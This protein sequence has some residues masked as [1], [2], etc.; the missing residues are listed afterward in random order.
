MAE[1]RPFSLATGGC[2]LAGFLFF[3]GWLHV[4]GVSGEFV[5]DLYLADD[6]VVEL[7]EFFGWHPQFDDVLSACLPHRVPGEE[8]RA[9]AELGDVSGSAGGDV[10][11]TGDL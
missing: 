7:A 8:L 11:V 6:V 3:R 10:P 2:G 9:N 4:L 5:D 1:F